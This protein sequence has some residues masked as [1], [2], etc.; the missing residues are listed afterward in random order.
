MRQYEGVTY[1]KA[2]KRWVAQSFDEHTHAWRQIHGVFRTQKSAADALAKDL[3]AEDAKDLEKGCKWQRRAD[4]L[5]HI[6]AANFNSERSQPIH[7]DQEFP[8]GAQSE[9]CLETQCP[10]W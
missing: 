5:M 4:I 2:K 8:H 6:K 7:G 9:Q 10:A 1:S 3:G